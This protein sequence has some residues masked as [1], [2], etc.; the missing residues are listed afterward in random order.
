M[1]AESRPRMISGRS[2]ITTGAALTRRATVGHLVAGAVSLMGT[3]TPEVAQ[4]QATP[5]ASEA[6][7]NHFELTGDKTE[8][9]YDTTKM[10]RS[11]LT[12]AGPHGHL[13]LPG[14]QLRDEQSAL[15]RMVTGSLGAFPDQGE[16]WLTLLLPRF[17]SLLSGDA[18]A[19]FT[20][21]AILKW[22]ISTIAG[23]PQTGALEEYRVVTLRGT[24]QVI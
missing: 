16:L 11:Q 21:I 22:V 8:L 13:V 9:R 18:P 23:P 1:K 4:A 14:E 7:P 19:P 2:S 15:G 3:L 12:Y 5:A 10:G 20:T 17:A 6:A 24:A